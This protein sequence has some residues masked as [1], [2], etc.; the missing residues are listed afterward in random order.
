M[1]FAEFKNEHKTCGSCRAASSK[2]LTEYQKLKKAVE[3][4]KK[5]NEDE[6]KEKVKSKIVFV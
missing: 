2:R 1:K 4:A 3:S 5:T 6:P